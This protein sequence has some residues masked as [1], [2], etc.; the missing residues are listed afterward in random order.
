MRAII[1]EEERFTELLALLRAKI[2]EDDSFLLVQ[3]EDMGIKMTAQQRKSL[4]EG[5]FRQFNYV[6]VRWAQSHGASCVR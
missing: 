3:L 5:L 4:R 1:I 6:F 2:E